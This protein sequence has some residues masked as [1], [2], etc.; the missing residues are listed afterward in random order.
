MHEKMVNDAAAYIR[1]LANMRGRNADWAEKAVRE[2]AS[3][4]AEQALK[5]GVIDLVA[6]TLDNLLARIN[7]RTVTVAGTERTLHTIALRIVPIEPDWRVEFLGILTNPNVAYILMLAGIFGLG[8][9][10]FNPG[11]FLPGVTGA[12]CLLLALYAFQLLPVNYAGL[13]LVVLGVALMVSEAFVTSFGALGFGGVAAFVIGSVMLLDTS[14]PG[15]RISWMLIGSIAL[16]SAGMFLFM[17]TMMM[18]A[19]RRAVVTG[20]EQMIGGLGQVIDWKGGR[21][22]VRIH[23]EIWKARSAA[24]LATGSNVKV[25][26]LDG[27]TLVV[28]PEGQN[29]EPTP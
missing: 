19:R 16:V 28:T 9:E 11:T 5:E 12:I 14:V 3:L 15:Y 6:P 13:G 27:L 26:D 23:G 1:S 8:L 7:G 29:K 22:H 21:G 18:R 4:P 17:M 20:K 10:F 2:A 25:D 24:P